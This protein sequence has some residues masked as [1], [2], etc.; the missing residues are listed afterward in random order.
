MLHRKQNFRLLAGSALFWKHPVTVSSQAP[1]CKMFV[2]ILFNSFV[3][4]VWHS[5]FLQESVLTMQ[6][7]S[8]REKSQ[9]LIRRSRRTQGKKGRVKLVLFKTED[10]KILAYNLILLHLTKNSCYSTLLNLFFPNYFNFK[11][12]LSL[13]TCPYDY[14][15]IL[16]CFMGT[17]R[18]I[19][20]FTFT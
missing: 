15:L 9:E 20:S 8:P 18:A 6:R 3:I 14:F 19:C 10:R 7:K 4:R 13:A 12:E 2:W 16:D 11:N 5:G 17:K 1:Y